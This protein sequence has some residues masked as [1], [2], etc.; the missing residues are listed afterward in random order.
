MAIKLIKTYSP[1]ENATRLK[2]QEQDAQTV[3][4]ALNKQSSDLATHKADP[5]AHAASQITYEGT[6][7][8]T[9]LKAVNAYVDNLVIEASKGDSNAEVVAARTNY[10]GTTDTSL[11]ARLD[12]YAQK[13]DNGQNFKLTTSGG[14]AKKSITEGDL[15]S[16]T[17]V[18]IYWC[19]FSN[20]TGDILN[21]PVKT[22]GWLEV[23]PTVWTTGC[24][25]RYTPYRSNPSTGT[26]HVYYRNYAIGAQS[27]GQWSTFADKLETDTAMAAINSQKINTT[28]SK[29]GDVTLS[30]DSYPIGLTIQETE[31]T[32]GWPGNWS[33]GIVETH[34]LNN[35]RCTQYFYKNGGTSPLSNG[36]WARHWWQSAGWG[37]WF[38]VFGENN[39][40]NVSVTNEQLLTQSLTQKVKFDRVINDSHG[41]FN[42]S[43]SR[44]TAKVRGL[45]MVGV[46]LYINRIK[47]Y[48]N[49]ELNLYRNGT[50]YKV[51]HNN[52]QAP[53][54]ET[55]NEFDQGH[56]ASGVTVPLEVGD[57]LE[58]FIFVGSGQ[59]LTIS[60][61][62]GQY[63]YFDIYRVG[64]IPQNVT[65]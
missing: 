29:V 54:N 8:E 32:A 2:Q 62:S 60:S 52:R 11:K 21:A 65:F 25:Q 14:L 48:S 4:D 51:I 36:A 12:R 34:K 31:G 50:R 41:Q 35:V 33:Y 45:Y 13:T 15:N 63:N 27:W 55:T 16:I 53:A 26:M 46:G 58:M 64:D 57:Y 20:A 39:W 61:K 24:L 17:E 6:N 38:S 10:D 22:S 9:A 18:G 28:T 44:F 59:D 7:V 23:V 56:Y 47:Q 19:D 1:N 43:S 30:G 49:V 37:P 40:C 5:K 42:T 3:E